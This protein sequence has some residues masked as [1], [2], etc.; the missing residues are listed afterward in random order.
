VKIVRFGAVGVL[1]TLLDFAT[2]NVLMVVFGATVGTPLLL[3][4]AAAFLVA[5]L[6][7]FFLNKKWTFAHKAPSSLKQYLVFLTL[8]LGGLAINSLVIGLLTAGPL[9]PARLSPALWVNT[10]K[11]G[12]TAA[13]MVWNYLACHYIVFR[14]TALPSDG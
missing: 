7:S 8:M 2:L 4:N 5:S 11:V 3:C 6:N 10:A 12:A 13:S 9:R 14:K 1:N